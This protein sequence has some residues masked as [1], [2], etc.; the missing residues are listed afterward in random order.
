MRNRWFVFALLVGALAVVAAGCGGGDDGGGAAQG[1]E[2]VTGDISAMA[3]W[4]GEEQ[5]SFQAV[6]DGFNELYPERQRQVH[7]GRRQPR[8]AALDRGRR[9]GTRP[10]S[11]ASAS[12]DS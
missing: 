1:S 9:A 6:I 5:A 10:T 8:A 2:D 4:G 3:I 7:V 12:P 11:P